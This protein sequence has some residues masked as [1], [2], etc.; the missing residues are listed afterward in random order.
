MGIRVEL[1]VLPTFELKQSLSANTL[2]Y[3]SVIVCV[4]RSSHIQN[5]DGAGLVVMFS[6]VKRPLPLKCVSR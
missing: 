3:I 6:Q 1:I 5:V 2:L 4:L